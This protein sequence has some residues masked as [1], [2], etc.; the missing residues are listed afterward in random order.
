MGRAL[1]SPFG[2]L[3]AE[4]RE[5]PQPARSARAESPAPAPRPGLEPD[6]RIE[7]RVVSGP[8]RL[9]PAR[10]R[11]LWAASLLFHAV[12]IVLLIVVPL[13]RSDV[14]PSPMHQTHAFFAAPASL[15]VPVPPPPPAA[16]P[17]VPRSA[18]RPSA[19]ATRPAP[20]RFTAPVDVPGPVVA[21]AA[22]AAPAAIV[23]DAHA[24]AGEPGVPGGTAGG[25]PGGIVGG[26]VGSVAPPPAPVAPVRVGGE[27]REPKKIRHVSPIYPDLAVAAHVKGTVILECLVSPQG[28]VT[29]VRL[30][31]GIPL[32]NESAMDAVKQWMYTPTL[33]DGIPVPVILTVT[34]RFDL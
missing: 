1:L 9:T 18:A 15:S 28:R 17:R 14:L 10:G 23:E 11:V 8:Q 22:E 31:R 30:M 29:D 16:A 5:E 26:V 25:L 34:V 24:A 7:T 13:L 33:K 2:A 4:I 20:A 3:L 6:L 27:I 21:A 19:P 32:L 12:L